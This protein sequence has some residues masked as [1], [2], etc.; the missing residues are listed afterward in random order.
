MRWGEAWDEAGEGR[1]WVKEGLIRNTE[2]LGLYADSDEEP[3]KS[4]TQESGVCWADVLEETTSNGKEFNC[5]TK[6]F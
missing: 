5:K 3:L 4:C 1:C 6:L 2:Q